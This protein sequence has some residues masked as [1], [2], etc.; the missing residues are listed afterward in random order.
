MNKMDLIDHVASAASLTRADATAAL[1]A[2]TLGIT[3]ALSRGEDVRL[4]GFGTFVVKDREA[5]IGRDP[6]TGKPLNISA[7]RAAGFKAG[8]ALKEALNKA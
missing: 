8:A 1:D 4:V 5:R 2:V 6:K 3:K 7:S